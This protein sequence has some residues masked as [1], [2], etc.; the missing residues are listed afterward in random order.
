MSKISK[1]KE[2]WEYMYAIY[3]AG[4]FSSAEPITKFGKQGWELIS[5]SIIHT[6]QYNY[7]HFA[8]FFKRRFL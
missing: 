8:M 2:R 1:K 6:G 4:F 7:E 5:C 3:Q